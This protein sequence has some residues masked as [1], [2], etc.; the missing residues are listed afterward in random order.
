MIKR[1]VNLSF[2]ENGNNRLS[3][4]MGSKVV[5]SLNGKFFLRY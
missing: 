4:M 3:N 2:V 5:S 1:S